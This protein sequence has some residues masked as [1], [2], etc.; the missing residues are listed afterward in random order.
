MGPVAR[1]GTGK[2]TYL[3]LVPAPY[4]LANYT[5]RMEPVARLG[6]D[7]PVKKDETHGKNP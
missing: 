7:L 4:A 5:P 2:T 1:T 6:T 3:A